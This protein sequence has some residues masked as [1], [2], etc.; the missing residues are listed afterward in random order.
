MKKKQV[1]ISSIKHT[2]TN[3]KRLDLG[4]FFTPYVDTI[5][6]KVKMLLFHKI[7]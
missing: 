5:F 4:Y 2:L 7:A 1:K 3:L 6:Y